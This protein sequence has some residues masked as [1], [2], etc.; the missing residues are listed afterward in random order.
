MGQFRHQFFL[1]DISLIFTLPG[2]S[3]FFPHQIKTFRESAK[4]IAPIHRQPELQITVGNFSGKL[5]HHP[6]GSENRRMYP[7][8]KQINHQHDQPKGKGDHHNQISFQSRFFAAIGQNDDLAQ[9]FFL[10]IRC[11]SGQINDR[12]SIPDTIKQ[13]GLIVFVGH[14]GNL[15]GHATVCTGFFCIA[16][17]PVLF[18]GFSDLVNLGNIDPIDLGGIDGADYSQISS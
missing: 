11:G 12:L 3:Q 5:L 9:Q 7:P 2:L 6:K 15:V 16:S 18:D 13:K 8:D 10:A 4:V 14:Q 1:A 17:V